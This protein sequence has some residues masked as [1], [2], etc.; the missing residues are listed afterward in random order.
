MALGDTPY[1]VGS[2]PLEV[3]DA[4]PLLRTGYMRN[5]FSGYNMFALESFMDELAGM[6]GVDPV[7]FRLAHLEDDR[8]ID[9]IRAATDAAG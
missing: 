6:S 2:M 3:F 7:E 1:Q 4:G 5:V 8:A 9:V